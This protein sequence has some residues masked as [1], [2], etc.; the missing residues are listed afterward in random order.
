MTYDNLPILS[1]FSDLKYGDRVYSKRFGI[2]KFIRLHQENQAIV[3]F[4]NFKKRIYLEDNDLSFVAKNSRKRGGNFISAKAN[5]EK[6]NLTTL[7]QTM[8]DDFQR[9]N[10]SIKDAKYF[11]I[12]ASKIKKWEKEGKITPSSIGQEKLYNFKKLLE[13]DKNNS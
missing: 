8:K 11:N 4:V 3:E 1:T 12:S 7:R 5:G 10:I 2:G 6:V 13:L 9:K